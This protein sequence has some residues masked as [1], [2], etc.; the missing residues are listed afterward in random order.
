MAANAAKSHEKRGPAQLQMGASREAG[1]V[2]PVLGVVQGELAAEK[3]STPRFL[4]E[5]GI[6]DHRCGEAWR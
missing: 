6:G 1:D 3:L 4:L 5:W 2:G